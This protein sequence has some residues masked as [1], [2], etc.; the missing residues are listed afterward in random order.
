MPLEKNRSQMGWCLVFALC[1]NPLMAD[2]PWPAETWNE[3]EDITHSSPQHNNLSGAYYNATD[4]YVLA[5]KQNDLIWKY[6]YDAGLDTWTTSG[7]IALPS[8]G[9]YE[10]ITMFDEEDDPTDGVRVLLMHEGNGGGHNDSTLYYVK[11]L[12]TSPSTVR[13][14]K[15]GCASGCNMPGE[16]G[17]SNGPEGIA[18]VSNTWLDDLGF[19]DGAG[20]PVL[21]TTVAENG[22]D[23]LIF[24]GHQTDGFIYV[25]DLKTDANDSMSF[26]GVYDTS[27]S[28]NEIAALEFDNLNGLLYIFHGAGNNTLE[29]TDLSSTAGGDADRVFTALARTEPA[30]GGSGYNL[31]GLAVIPPDMCASQ[32]LCWGIPAT[33]QIFLTCDDC[34]VAIKWMEGLAGDWINRCPPGCPDVLPADMNCD[35]KTDGADIQLFVELLVG[36]GYACQADMNGDRTFD[37]ADASAFVSVLLEAK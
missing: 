13:T 32:N 12:F 16:V 18:F 15:V 28:F 26:I 7:S 30:D 34:T 5:L 9:D 2:I 22:L 31:E 37:S 6:T 17:N 33:G 27:S 19:V 21:G 4:N 3:G 23:G 36:G 8:A 25:F 10:A 14:W 29:V 24:V 35:D 1:A 11:D 20:D